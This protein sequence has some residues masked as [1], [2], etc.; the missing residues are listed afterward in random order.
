M[1]SP[2]SR[3]LDKFCQSEPLK[4]FHLVLQI[5]NKKVYMERWVKLDLKIFICKDLQKIVI[6]FLIKQIRF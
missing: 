5:E 3:S 2:E 4:G 6:L 1:Q